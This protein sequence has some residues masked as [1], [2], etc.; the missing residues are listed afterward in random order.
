MQLSIITVSDKKLFD[1]TWLEVNTT[2]GNFVLQQGHAPMIL[3]L[4]PNKPFI[5]CLENGKEESVTVP[6][7][8]LHIDREQA[9]VVIT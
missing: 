8:V 4:S 5:F 1:V 7:G 9:T 6:G 2:L 3:V